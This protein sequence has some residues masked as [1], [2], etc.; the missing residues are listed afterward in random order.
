MRKFTKIGLVIAVFG[1]IGFFSIR[2]YVYHGGKR[3]IQTEKAAFIVS[4]SAISEEFVS[5]VE[6]ANKKY[7]EKTVE[8]SGKVT[9]VENQN[10]IIDNSIN[11]SFSQSV[12]LPEKGQTVIVKG[13]VVG[14]DDLL[15][16][17]KLD[18]CILTNK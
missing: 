15:E 1:I 13:R 14:F 4:S 7:L 5:S 12:N 8:V 17:L 2:Y 9:D 6:L 16:E 10:V 3:D 18:Q 11:C